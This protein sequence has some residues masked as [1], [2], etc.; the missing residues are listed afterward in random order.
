M[1]IIIEELKKVPSTEIVNYAETRTGIDHQVVATFDTGIFANGII[2]DHDAKIYANWWPQPAPDKAEFKFHYT[3]S[4]GYDCG[5]HRQKN[6]HVDGLDHFQERTDSEEEYEY[7]AVEFEQDNPTG[8][9][10]EIADDKLK[11]RVQTQHDP[12]F[13]LSDFTD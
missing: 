10:W 13:R 2:A 3:D 7:E 6:E 8:L 11:R 4:S 1:T 9:V 5:W 12:N